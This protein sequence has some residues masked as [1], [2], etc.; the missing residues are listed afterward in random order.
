MTAMCHVVCAYFEILTASGG[1]IRWKSKLI[2][3]KREVVKYS[4]CLKICSSL[5]NL[6]K[7]L[8]HFLIKCVIVFIT[9][10]VVIIEF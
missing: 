1:R 5:L 9:I 7:E 6:C 10:I 3:H 4:S 2:I 8:L